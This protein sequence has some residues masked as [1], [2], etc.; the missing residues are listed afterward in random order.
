MNKLI[1]AWK[2]KKVSS[3][4]QIDQSS[5][6][7]KKISL[8]RKRREKPPKNSREVAFSRKTP[9]KIASL[10]I[11]SVML[12]SL[13][14]NIIHFSN[15]KS[16]RD[17]VSASQSNIDEQ[18]TEIED[19]DLI[20]SD[21]VRVYASDF[22]ED[23]Y[24]IPE[25]SEARVERE[26]TLNRYFVNDFAFNELENIE[27]FQGKRDISSSELVEVNR[28][29]SEEANVH[30]KVTYVVSRTVEREAPVEEEEDSSSDDEETT[31]EMDESE[32]VEETETKYNTVEA[33]V[34]VA[35]DGEGFAIADKPHITTRD[36]QSTM[37]HEEEA[38]KGNEVSS[39]EQTTLESFLTGFFTAYG[40][41]ADTLE[42]LSNKENGL[43]RQTFEHINIREAA[44]H[45]DV[46]TVRADVTYNDQ[47]T[48]V[49][50]T[51]SYEVE[52]SQ[53]TGELFVETVH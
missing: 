23:Y 44:I 3:N 53:E 20:E 34:P 38:L 12:L 24:T 7:K 15:I 46:Y 47:D 16:I 41:S 29:N 17:T 35:T 49:S 42:F 32:T 19:G 52:V 18:L 40:E 51:Y 13:L 5:E 8:N 26:E 45:E 25:A 31:E 43:Q 4:E 33:V 22:I 28:V 10:V 1:Q 36:L 50:S 27:E 6:T 14:F 2:N 48:N 9:A 37:E 39:S 11:F 30:F 21:S